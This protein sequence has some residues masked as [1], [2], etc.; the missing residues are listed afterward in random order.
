MLNLI[1]SVLQQECKQ[2]SENLDK[3]RITGSRLL[4][5][6]EWRMV[7]RIFVSGPWQVWNRPLLVYCE[8]KWS[9]IFTIAIAFPIPSHP[10]GWRTAT[11]WMRCS[12]GIYIVS[13]VNRDGTWN[14]NVS[15]VTPAVPCL[16]FAARVRNKTRVTRRTHARRPLV[17]HPLHL[18][19]KLQ[20]QRPALARASLWLSTTSYRAVGDRRRDCI[21]WEN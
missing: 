18:R 13:V 5:S 10:V 7:S 17:N 3:G 16:P 6:T 1:S 4:P 14:G 12:E 8:G 19:R 20:R 9:C 15:L 2:E 11:G 21:R